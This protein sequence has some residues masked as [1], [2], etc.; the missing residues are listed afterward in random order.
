[1]SRDLTMEG[2]AEAAGLSYDRFRKVW[3]RLCERSGFPAPFKGGDDG[4]VSYA[5]DREAVETWRRART[6]RTVAPTA[7][8]PEPEPSAGDGGRRARERLRQLQEGFA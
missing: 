3:R 2:A 4:R 1:M 6:G 7:R 8:K 5:W